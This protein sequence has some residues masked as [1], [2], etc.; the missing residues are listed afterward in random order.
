[1]RTTRLEVSQGHQTRL[2]FPISV[3]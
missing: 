1:M 2:C 3:L